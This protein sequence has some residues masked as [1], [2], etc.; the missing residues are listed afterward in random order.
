MLNKKN[1]LALLTICIMQHQ[2]AGAQT[3]PKID[4][5][6]SNPHYQQ[7]LEFFQSMPDR[8]KEIVFLGNSIT[9]HGEWQ[10]LIPRKN[11]VN[12]GIG[13]DNTF[14]LLARVGEV[15]SSKP[16]KIFL[17]IGINDLGRGL[18]IPVIV[19]NYHRIISRIKTESPRTTLYIQSILPMNDSVLKAAYLKGKKEQVTKLNQ[20]LQKLA[21]QYKI[22]WINL[23]E[24]FADEKGDL[25]KELTLDGIHLRA[26]AYILWV[27]YLKRKKYL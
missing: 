9:E 21:A 24:V 15:L 22:Q 2:N 16:K 4:S 25:K 20:E 6:Y 17:L 12:R 26:P 19:N 3:A 1:I 27:D 14:G 8:S 23:H 5:N 10:E 11:V 18:P 7:R 13:G